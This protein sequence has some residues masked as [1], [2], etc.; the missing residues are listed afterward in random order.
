[1]LLALGLYRRGETLAGGGG[2]LLYSIGEY[3]ISGVC[4]YEGN[5][6]KIMDK[7]GAAAK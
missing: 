1:M 2:G 4:V 3:G 6:V 7:G 5:G